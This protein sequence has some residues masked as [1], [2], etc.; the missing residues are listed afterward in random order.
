M[1]HSSLISEP[2]V[3]VST[4]NFTFRA[5]EIFPLLEN[6]FHVAACSLCSSAYYY[7]ISFWQRLITKF[8]KK[9]VTSYLLEKF[10]FRT[11]TH[12]STFFINTFSQGQLKIKFFHKIICFSVLIVKQAISKIVK[13]IGNSISKWKLIRVWR[14]ELDM[15]PLV[16]G[17]GGG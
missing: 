12:V 8:Y 6:Y 5:K 2:S 4:W 16:L 10:M 3:F 9:H 15:G 11:L 7:D 17:K 13:R 14:L 1:A